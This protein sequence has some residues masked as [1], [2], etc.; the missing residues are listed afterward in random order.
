M[1]IFYVIKQY[2]II[3]CITADIYHLVVAM[4]QKNSNDMKKLFLGSMMFLA[5]FGYC[6]SICM[7]EV[8][9]VNYWN[10]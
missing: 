3:E 9:F 1:V 5:C 4:L 10:I 8:K 6:N 7:K 2:D